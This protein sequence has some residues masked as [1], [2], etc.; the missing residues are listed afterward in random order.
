MKCMKRNLCAKTKSTA[1]IVLQL[2]FTVLLC[3][4]ASDAF[5]Q[6]YT[7]KASYYSNAFHGRRCANGEKYDMYK[8]T[9]AH[10]SLPFGTKLKVTNQKN[11]K[12][13]IV[14]VTD[15]GPYARGRIIDLSKAAAIELG[16]V[17]SGVTT[18]T[19][20]VINES[21]ER[22]STA[23]T[24]ILSEPEHTDESLDMLPHLEPTTEYASLVR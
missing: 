10:K 16:M 3:S 22:A 11:G 12:T 5:A 18:V 23:P 20:E 7:G 2:I 21:S 9:C 17:A 14:K 4:F 24:M 8:L 19:V 1:F 6:T 15:R 13:T